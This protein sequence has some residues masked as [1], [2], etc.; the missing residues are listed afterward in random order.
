MMDVT[1]GGLIL[2]MAALCLALVALGWVLDNVR[3]KK[4]EIVR[5][6]GVVLCRICGVRYEANAGE[7]TPCPACQTPNEAGTA[8]S[9]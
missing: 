8:D 1:L 7:V 6:R 2:L 3:L 5:K 9:I 4:R